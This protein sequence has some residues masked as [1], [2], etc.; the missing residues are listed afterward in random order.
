MGMKF[1]CQHLLCR[2]DLSCTKVNAVNRQQRSA[3]SFWLSGEE[4]LPLP[5]WRPSM[6]HAGA[7]AQLSAD[8]VLGELALRQM[9]QNKET[10]LSRL[11]SVLSNW[12]WSTEEKSNQLPS[13]SA[14]F[15]QEN[16]Q[17]QEVVKCEFLIKPSQT[18]H[19]NL[20][21]LETVLVLN[22][23]SHQG[24]TWMNTWWG[25]GW[26]CSWINPD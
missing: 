4:R 17:T 20:K 22:D 2:R 16:R 18:H 23:A 19:K 13:G 10:Q 26:C 7:R 11:V 9:G 21:I 1:V 6:F 24:C 3:R 14:V 5:W 25:S 12:A 8:G 15:L